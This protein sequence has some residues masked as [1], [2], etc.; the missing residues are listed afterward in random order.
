SF[1]TVNPEFKYEIA[2]AEQALTDYNIRI[3]LETVYTLLKARSDVNQAIKQAGPWLAG[4]VKRTDLPEQANLQNL[5]NALE[6]YLIDQFFIEDRSLFK[7]IVEF[8]RKFITELDKLGKQ[9]FSE[10]QQLTNP[11]LIFTTNY[12]NIIETYARETKRSCYDGYAPQTAGSPYYVFNET[13]LERGYEILLFKLHGSVTLYKLKTDEIIKPHSKLRK[14]SDFLGAQVVENV[15]I[16]PVQ[17]KSVSKDPYNT[18]DKV[19]R[20]RLRAEGQVCIVVGHAF[21][22]EAILSAFTDSMIR[23][24]NLKVVLL[25]HNPDK[26]VKEKFPAFQNRIHKMR[27]EVKKDGGIE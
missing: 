24:P 23:N 27:G 11:L 26:I 16:F 14:G 3:D 4:L 17:E 10:F 19:L 21:N 5:L 2:N 12:D 1:V 18:L 22:D 25:S 8:Y 15:M 13:E 6:S 20:Q 7:P 9:Y